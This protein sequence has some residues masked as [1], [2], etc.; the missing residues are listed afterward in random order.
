MQEVQCAL[1]VGHG[2]LHTCTELSE[3][4]LPNTHQSGAT[5]LRQQLHKLQQDYDALKILLTDTRGQI[6]SRQ[7]AW[8]AWQRAYTQ[9]D[10]W[11]KDT[12]VRLHS[13]DHLN[14]DLPEKKAHMDKIKV[15]SFALLPTCMF[16][17]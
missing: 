6:E 7:Q 4:V 1:D 8:A 9:L 2:K 16:I 10:N 13:H 15:R 3:R 11:V 12:N 14:S 5:R 17:K